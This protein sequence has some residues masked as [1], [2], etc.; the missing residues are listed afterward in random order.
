MNPENTK[1]TSGLAIAGLVIAILA[2]LGSALPIINNVSFVFAIVSLVFGIVGLVSIKKGKRVGQGIAIAT[3]ILSAV[4]MIVVFATQAI[5]GKVADNI[6]TSVNESVD[7]FNGTN[8][9]KLLKENV[10]V[11]LGAFVFDPGAEAA[12]SYDDTFELPVTIKNKSSEKA[13]YTV[14]VEAVDASGTRLADDTIYVSD[15]NPGQS[16]SEKAF[17]FVEEGK[18]EAVKSATFKVLEVSK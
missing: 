18:R 7:N 14:K 3:I 8:T 9:E 16:V 10:D 11:T 13:S 5:Y 1:R 4:T 15:L 2:I 17:K 12:F 6:S